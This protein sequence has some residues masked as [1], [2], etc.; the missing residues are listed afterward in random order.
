MLEPMCILLYTLI[1][2]KEVWESHKISSFFGFGSPY[3]NDSRQVGSVL[4]QSPV[5]SIVIVGLA[6][7]SAS[8]RSAQFASQ[9]ILT[10]LQ[11]EH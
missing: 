8:A 10:K 11:H 1:D 3:V 2:F 9:R 4:T 7:I 5:A 6:K